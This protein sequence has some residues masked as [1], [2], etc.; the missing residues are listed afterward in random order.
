MM[1]AAVPLTP[2]QVASL[3][4]DAGALAAG[5]K[6]ADPRAWRGLGRSAEALWGE[7]QGSAVYQVRVA[8]QDLAARCSCP[9]RK[10][11]CKHALGLL[12]LAAQAP[13]RLPE[14]PPPAWVAEWLGKRGEAAGKKRERAARAEAA[15][16]VDLEAQAKRAEKRAARVAAGIDGLERWLCDLVRTGLAATPPG[17]PAWGAQAARLVDAQ[18]PGLAARVRQL[19]S[20]PRTGDGWPERLA[21][22]LGRL[23][24]LGQAV[25]RLCELEPALA[26]EIRTLVGWT[27]E[28]EEVLAAGA[29]VADEWAIVGQIVVDEE[30]VRIQRTYLRGLRS[31]RDALVL[32]FAVGAARFPEALPP[33]AALEAELAFWPGSAPL[34]ALVAERRS[35]LTPIAARPAAAPTIAAFLDAHARAL[36]A[37]PFLD[38]VPA[39]LADVVPVAT[40]GGFVVADG[41]GAALPLA[42][43][44]WT[45]VAIAGGRPVDVFGEWDGEALRALGA[46]AEGRHHALGGGEAPA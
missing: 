4:P 44:P 19:G 3:A 18:A 38:R 16:P 20:L 17:D 32:Q 40:A 33:G 1:A 12:F 21:G 8:T 27:M 43:A 28:R 10:F 15:P 29:R 6:T 37:Q 23:A 45:L 39:A 7:C 36:A 46:Y 42:G 41:A 5:R 25:R 24:L 31:G 14:A 22:G 9:S 13:D 35:E 26:A 30:R 34:R 11:P 2:E